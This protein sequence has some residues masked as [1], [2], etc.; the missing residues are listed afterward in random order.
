VRK[1]PA[2]VVAVFASF[3]VLAGCGEDASSPELDLVQGALCTPT[4]LAAVAAVASP[5]PKQPA[6]RAIDGNTGTRWE[7]AYSDPQWIYA[8]LGSVKT[9]TEIKIDWQHAAAKD[10]RIDV[11][12]DAVNWSAPVVT[13]TG[14][15]PVDHRI[16]D[17]TGFTVSA[18]YV[19]VYGTARA[20]AYGYSIWEL[21]I[22][23]GS[24]A[25]TGTGGSGGAGAG[26]AGSGG[27]GA[28][29]AGAG[30]TGGACKNDNL[31]TSAALVATSSS[32]TPSRAFDNN[33]GTRW[34][35]AYSDPQWIV[36]DLGALEKVREVRIDWQHAAAKDYRI[37]VS[38]DGSSW[39]APIVTK[40][41]GAPVDHRID[42]FVGLSANARYVRMYGTARATVY[43]YS[44]WEMDVFGDANPGCS[45]GTGA[46]GSGGTGAGGSGGTGAGG[47]GGAGA[48]GTGAPAACSNGALPLVGAVASSNTQPASRAIDGNLTTR[49]ESAASDPQWIYADLGAR[50]ALREVKI[51]WETASAA[52]YEID[53]SDDATNW[54]PVLT[55]AGL[56]S[57]QHRKDDTLGIFGAGRYV[58]ILG[59]TRSS[60]WGY[61]IWELS[62]SG[63]A[64]PSCGNLLTAG[65]DRANVASTFSPTAGYAFDG[66]NKNAVSFDYTGQTFTTPGAPQLLELTQSLKIPKAG[67]QWRVT[68]DISGMND[69]AGLPP[70]FLA[71]LAGVPVTAYL[72]A[73]A[74]VA[75]SGGQLI[76]VGSLT[77][78]R[79]LIMDFGV[80]LA[81]NATVD[82][83]LDN[84]PTFASEGTGN[85][86]GLQKFKV[87][88]VTLERLDLN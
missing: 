5:S 11:S 50:K 35:S 87:T 17:L 3:I 78:G 44:I 23:D 88:D 29:G 19:R 45:G 56:G 67:T 77:T 20:T 33:A 68:L 4:K 32:G 22:Y 1:A 76:K 26:G 28:G 72:P 7:S 82:L 53:V 80:S 59:L 84:V 86:T 16:D 8:D 15:A 63:D 36:V 61:S 55:R 27:A 6:S 9:V 31:T 18:R 37:D 39:S 2:A 34:E 64:N 60:Q 74:T 21:S 13:K 48:G 85:G 10:Y 40:T 30:G 75:S 52:S 66:T 58:R 47:S 57:V 81:A 69:Q 70:R 51:D 62:A 24:C 25:G 65:W 54:S 73:T 14:G 79:K 42:D 49:W 46:G 83:V 43:G 38:S 41:G 71:T 12:N